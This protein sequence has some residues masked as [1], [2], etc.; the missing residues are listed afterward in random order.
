M[1]LLIASTTCP[2]TLQKHAQKFVEAVVDGH[3]ACTGEV[4]SQAEG[5]K[6]CDQ[7]DEQQLQHMYFLLTR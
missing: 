7:Y 1:Q 5:Q 4:I 2:A 6:R 3:L